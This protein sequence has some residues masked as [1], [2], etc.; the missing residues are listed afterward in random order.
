MAARSI[1]RCLFR[2]DRRGAYWTSSVGLINFISRTVERHASGKTPSANQPC[3]GVLL[4]LTK[5]VRMCHM[6]LHA[7]TYCTPHVSQYICLFRLKLL[8]SR[9]S[10]SIYRSVRELDF[11]DHVQRPLRR[12]FRTRQRAID[13]AATV[14][15]FG[16]PAICSFFFLK[17]TRRHIYVQN[18]CHIVAIGRQYKEDL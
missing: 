14:S 7:L 16:K 8:I 2:K 5:R 6:A 9:F 17:K 4:M 12:S 1:A 18:S 3:E 10:A 13:L 15:S 11:F